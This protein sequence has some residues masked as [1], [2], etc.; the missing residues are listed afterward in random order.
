LDG[1]DIDKTN[2][3]GQGRKRKENR[4]LFLMA[5]HGQN[6]ISTSLTGTFTATMT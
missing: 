5:P 2:K 6:A 3:E 1:Q 4:T